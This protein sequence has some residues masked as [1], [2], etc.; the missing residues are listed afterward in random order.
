MNGRLAVSLT[1]WVAWIIELSLAQ[2]K[3]NIKQHSRLEFSHFLTHLAIYRRSSWTAHTIRFRSWQRCRTR[4]FGRPP[5]SRLA[6]ACRAEC[7]AFSREP[8]ARSWKPM[9]MIYKLDRFQDCR[10]IYVPGPANRFP[11][12]LKTKVVGHSCDLAGIHYRRLK[13]KTE[14]TNLPQPMSSKKQ[15]W[16]S[17]VLTKEPQICICQLAVLWWWDCRLPYWVHRYLVFSSYGNVN[18]P[19]CRGAFH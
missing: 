7:P 11:I 5:S 12:R 1:R 4:Y 14:A 16:I 2:K 13:Q 15:S 18:W 8:K 3:R 10:M 17:H 6:S 9:K 19:R